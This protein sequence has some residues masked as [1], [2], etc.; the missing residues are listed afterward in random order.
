M[1]SNQ[2][3]KLWHRQVILRQGCA[4]DIPWPNCAATLS[5][6]TPEYEVRN[7]S[8]FPITYSVQK[9][10]AKLQSSRTT[11]SLASVIGG[12]RKRPNSIHLAY[13]Q[14]KWFLRSTQFLSSGLRLENGWKTLPSVV[15]FVSAVHESKTCRKSWQSVGWKSY[16]GAL[17]P[18]QT[19]S[20]VGSPAGSHR[21]MQSFV[22]GQDQ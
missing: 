11:R 6:E 3:V 7:I 16:Y 14:Q 8:S 13:R 12:Q 22:R 5:T 15:V 20:E 18:K 19:E 1:T 4:E 10:E 17:V 2:T 21:G 9:M